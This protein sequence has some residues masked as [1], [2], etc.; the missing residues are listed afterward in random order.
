[1]YVRHLKYIHS[2]NQASE[3]LLSVLSS[4]LPQTAMFRHPAFL[5]I[6]FNKYFIIF[7]FVSMLNPFWMWAYVPVRFYQDSPYPV[8][9]RMESKS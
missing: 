4:H 1:M 8:P 5:K 2:Q 6:F 9:S 7:L 3:R